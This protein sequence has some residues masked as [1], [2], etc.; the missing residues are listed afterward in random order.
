MCRHDENGLT[1]ETEVI[2]QLNAFSYNS[3]CCHGVTLQHN[4]TVTATEVS[5]RERVA[6]VTGLTVRFTGEIQKTG[7]WAGKVVGCF[8]GLEKWLDALKGWKSGWMLYWAMPG[9]AWKTGSGPG[10]Q[11]QGSGARESMGQARGT[12]TRA[13]GPRARVRAG[14]VQGQSQG[15]QGQGQ[16][17]RGQYQGRA[18]RAR[19]RARGS[20]P[21]SG[22]PGPGGQEQ[23]QG[24]V[25]HSQFQ[26]KGARAKARARTR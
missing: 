20:G 22:G 11:G 7:L 24:Q 3:C 1:S 26:G 23:C 8:T 10:C 18:R 16:G 25:G 2:P 9:K 17:Q 12:R 15:S 14:G 21:G 6:S 19:A 5:T 4:R 13:L